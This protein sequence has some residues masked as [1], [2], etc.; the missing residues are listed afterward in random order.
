MLQ[1]YT[2]SSFPKYDEFTERNCF[3]GL[4][5][6]LLGTVNL[7]NLAHSVPIYRNFQSNGGKWPRLKLWIKEFI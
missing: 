2:N 4:G 6:T 5:K 7:K 1:N 3:F